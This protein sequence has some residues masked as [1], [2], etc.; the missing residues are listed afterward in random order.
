MAA[1][2]WSKIEPS[3]NVDESN[4]KIQQNHHCS[5]LYDYMNKWMIKVSRNVIPFIS[6]DK[7]YL[8]I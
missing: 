7:Y 3:S 8:W 5:L 2:F 6:S 4:F 1:I